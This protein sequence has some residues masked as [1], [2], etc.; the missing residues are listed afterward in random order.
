[1]SNSCE[2]IMDDLIKCLAKSRCVK[3]GGSYK[4]CLNSA[5]LEEECQGL[6][7]LYT[8]HSPYTAPRTAPRCLLLW[9]QPA[10]EGRSLDEPSVAGYYCV[11]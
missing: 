4:D 6:Y 2:G 9:L 3:E 1:M 8:G 11:L 7:T 10:D 5:T